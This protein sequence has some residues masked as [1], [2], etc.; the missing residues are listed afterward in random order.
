M[1]SFGEHDCLFLR[2]SKMMRTLNK[3]EMFSRIKNMF[4]DM[5]VDTCIKIIYQM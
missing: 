5:I 1:L 4:R 2:V 3:K